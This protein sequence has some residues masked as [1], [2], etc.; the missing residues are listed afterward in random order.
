M[1]N[2]TKGWHDA[3]NEG[4]KVNVDHFTEILVKG[5]R[6]RR[7]VSAITW[8]P[9]GYHA[10]QPR[11]CYHLRISTHRAGKICCNILKSNIVPARTYH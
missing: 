3:A 4:I 6:E 11:L 2:E 1:T 8:R 10:V 5:L 7:A 9:I